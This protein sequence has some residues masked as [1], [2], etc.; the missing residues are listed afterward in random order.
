MLAEVMVVR[1][2]SVRGVVACKGGV[3]DVNVVVIPAVVAVPAGLVAPG[4]T[5]PTVEGVVAPGAKE[6]V[7]VGT[8]TEQETIPDW[9]KGFASKFPR[10]CSSLT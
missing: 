9:Y 8:A 10:P 5:P 6:L 1:V 4:L 7:P 2:V 3:C